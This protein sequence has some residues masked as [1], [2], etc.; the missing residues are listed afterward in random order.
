MHNSI[1][2]RICLS[3]HTN[4][5]STC[6]NSS[7]RKEKMEVQ[8]SRTLNGT[9]KELLRKYGLN[10]GHA[11]IDGIDTI[12]RSG[13]TN[14]QFVIPA[15][16]N[17]KCEVRFNNRELLSRFVALPIEYQAE[18]LTCARKAMYTEQLMEIHLDPEGLSGNKRTIKISQVPIPF[19]G[20]SIFGKGHLVISS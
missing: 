6:G 14:R 15:A 18:V 2:Y 10:G 1:G 7:E 13:P 12:L 20:E 16:D 19:Q 4:L 8:T 9:L 11:N 17:A 3:E 5:V